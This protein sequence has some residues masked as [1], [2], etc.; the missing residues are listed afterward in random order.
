MA[1]VVSLDVYGHLLRSECFDK[2]IAQR[3]A[4]DM[5]SK[6]PGE[7]YYVGEDGG[8]EINVEEI[9]CERC[10]LKIQREREASSR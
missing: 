2:G 9:R 3:V 10:R 5:K 4:E 1:R 7:S 6:E 8:E